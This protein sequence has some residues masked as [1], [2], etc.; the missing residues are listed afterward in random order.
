MKIFNKLEEIVNIKETVVALGNFDGVHK[1]HQELISR[2]MR[3]SRSEGLKSAVFTFSNHPKNVLSGKTVVKSILYDEEKIKI[4]EDCGIDYLFNLEFNKKIAKMEP[5]RFIDELLLGKFNMKQAYCGFN[6]TFGSKAKGTPETLMREGIKK[7]FG[8]HV[9]EPVKVDGE[10]VSSTLIRDFIEEGEMDKCTRFMG[11]RYEIGGEVVVGNRL[12][13]TIGF[14]TSNLIIDETMV[15]P[16]NGVY[17]TNCIYNGVSYPSVTNVGHK[18]TI[19]EYS[20]NIETHIFDFNKELYGKQI[21]VEFITKIRDE[22]KFESVEALSEQI[23]KDCISAK[24]YHRSH[25]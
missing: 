2:C 10:I 4:I 23:K 7:G 9:I 16:A 13:R 19:G 6:F 22:K 12:G 20:K 15:S 8:I 3:T 1:G 14:P 5:V 17:I 24:A 21:L 11:R 18:P 25:R